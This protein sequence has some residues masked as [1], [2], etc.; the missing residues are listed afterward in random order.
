[1]LLFGYIALKK[2]VKNNVLAGMYVDPPWN[3]ENKKDIFLKG[4]I[5][6]LRSTGQSLQPSKLD[7]GHSKANL[8]LIILYIYSR[9][10]FVF[11]RPLLF[12]VQVNGHC[13]KVTVWYSKKHGNLNLHMNLVGWP[14]WVVCRS[15][16]V[17]T[18]TQ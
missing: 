16:L 13:K 2:N 8:N 17:I 15:T 1:M 12:S 4:V 18:R 10:T 11:T 3:S 14:S 9:S 5:G 7:N 6:Q